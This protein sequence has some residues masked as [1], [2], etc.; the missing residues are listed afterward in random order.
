[1]RVD[2]MPDEGMESS[3]GQFF[4]ALSERLTVENRISDV[5]YAAMLSSKEVFNIIATKLDLPS[6]GQPE[7]FRE[8]VCLEGRP[9]F[10]IKY[11]KNGIPHLIEIKLYDRNYHYEDYSKILIDGVKPKVALISAHK[12]PE[13]AGWTKLMW[14]ELV[15]EMEKS[16]NVFVA[17]LARFFRRAIMIDELKMIQFGSPRAILY[18]NRALKKIINSYESP[19]VDK[20]INNSSKTFGEDQSGYDYFLRYRA[21]TKQEVWVRFSLMYQDVVEG[22]RLWVGKSANRYYSQIVRGLREHYGTRLTEESSGVYVMMEDHQYKNLLSS[23]GIEGQISLLQIFFKEFN[24]V[25]ER[26]CWPK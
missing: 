22:V 24:T 18:F 2:P 5:L 6:E 9:D 17:H 15:I 23:Q 4:E 19:I 11:P 8:Y 20:G 1:M 21:D 3:I 7:I 16:S 13:L 12:L 25:I 10:L 14:E 26:T